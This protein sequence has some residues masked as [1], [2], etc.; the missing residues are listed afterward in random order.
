M[1]DMNAPEG[2]PVPHARA[3]RNA[4]STTHVEAPPPEPGHPS[5][6]AEIASLGAV[7]RLLAKGDASSALAALEAHDR[8]FPSPSLGPEALLVRLEALVLLGR[9][10]EARRYGTRFLEANPNSAHTQRVRSLI[11]SKSFPSP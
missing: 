10:D 11:G 7:Q 2:N 9:K 6:A 3:P 8:A 5:L 4:A 1:V